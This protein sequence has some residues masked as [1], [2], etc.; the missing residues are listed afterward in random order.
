MVYRAGDTAYATTILHWSD[1]DPM[2]ICSP[3]PLQHLAM[4]PEVRPRSLP[5]RCASVV[6]VHLQSNDPPQSCS[7]RWLMKPGDLRQRP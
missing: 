1:L 3:T 4:V 5:A 2:C 7:R 6:D